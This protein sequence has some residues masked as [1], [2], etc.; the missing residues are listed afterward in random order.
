M[1]TRSSTLP[2]RQVRYWLFRKQNELTGGAK[3]RGHPSGFYKQFEDQSAFTLAGGYANFAKTWDVDRTDPFSIIP[4][5][6]SIAEEWN[7]HLAQT[8]KPLQEVD[9][10]M[11]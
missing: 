5:D 11:R 8:A 1:P 7:H 9:L 2:R 4:R 3:V 10:G 6:Q